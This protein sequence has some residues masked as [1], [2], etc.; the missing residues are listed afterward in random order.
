MKLNIGKIILKNFGK[1]FE[2]KIL[3]K[4]FFLIV[5]GIVYPSNFFKICKK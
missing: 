3:E 2:K 5:G 4:M 1:N